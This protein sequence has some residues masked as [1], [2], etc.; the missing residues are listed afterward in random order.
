VSFGISA[1]THRCVRLEHPDP[2]QTT[3]AQL[4]CN[5]TPCIDITESSRNTTALI[6]I[7]LLKEVWGKKKQAAESV[8]RKT[9]ISVCRKDVIRISKATL[10]FWGL[11]FGKKR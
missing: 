2:Q 11:E 8:D 7:V 4:L 5:K 10:M 3:K 6:R 9:S 1:L